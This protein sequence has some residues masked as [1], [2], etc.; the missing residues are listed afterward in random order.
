MSAAV[1]RDGSALPDGPGVA[2]YAATL[3]SLPSAPPVPR[4][5][6]VLAVAVEPARLSAAL[7][8]GDGT[9]VVRDRVAMPAREVWRSLERLV[10]RVTAAAPGSMPPVAMVGAS[11]VGPVDEQAGTVWPPYVPTW[12]AFSLRDHLEEL[13]ETPTL[14]ASA[15]AAAAEAER[16]HGEAADVPSYLAVV[17]DAVVDSACVIDGVRLSGAHGDAGSIAHV[18]VDP[19]GLAC[20]CGSVGCLE[21]YLS[22]IALEA[23]LN[24][25]LRRANPSTVERAGIMLGRA[26]ATACATLDV[27]TVFVTGGVLD[28]LG[29]G[30]LQTARRELGE[31]ARLPNLAD[32]AIVEPVEHIT[33][34]VR[35]ASLARGRGPVATLG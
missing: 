3:V 7:V 27:P 31:R 6:S 34:L 12:S 24:R 11:C 1:E 15:G 28:A 8:D 21:P 5:A 9:V 10:R 22:R 16:L 17:A 18:T 25:P 20:W 13:V 35:A 2:R 29:D 33:P 4:D 19:G 23:E 32:L 30:L 26:L 14:V